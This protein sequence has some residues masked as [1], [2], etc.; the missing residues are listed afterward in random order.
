[1]PSG[2]KVEAQIRGS[3]MNIYVYGL[4]R[5]FGKTFGLC[6]N[7]DDDWKNDLWDHK[8]KTS[9]PA[10]GRDSILHHPKILQFTNIYKFV[11]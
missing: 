4:P 3:G 1:M 7:Y 6:G 2:S 11:S 5:D 9:F 8:S 10:Y